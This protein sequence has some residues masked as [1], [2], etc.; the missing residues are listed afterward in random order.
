MLL[1]H[2]AK[3]D[4][5]MKRFANLADQRTTRHGNDNVVG[6]SPAKLFGNLITY[7]L[8]ALR[9]VG[10]QI[11]VHEAPCVLVGNLG[12]EAVYVVIIAVDANQPRAIDLRV[13]NLCRLKLSRNQ[14]AGLDAQTSG[15]RGNRVC[16]IPRGRAADGI[17]TEALRI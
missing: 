1:L 5:L 9:V 7:G 12:A 11:D 2:E 16:Q 10:T 8:R 14:D 13:Q 17:E 6:E 3:I 4:K 15:L